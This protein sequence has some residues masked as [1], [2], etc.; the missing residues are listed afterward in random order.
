MRIFKYFPYLISDRG[1]RED[2]G[3]RDR[4]SRWNDERDRSGSGGDDYRGGSVIF[5]CFLYF[6][7][8]A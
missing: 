2:R 6:Q 1:S 7:L 3:G 4:P 5:L 8:I